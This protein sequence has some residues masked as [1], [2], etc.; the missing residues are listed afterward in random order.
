MSHSKQTNH[1]LSVSPC[2]L[3]RTSSQTCARGNLQTGTRMPPARRRC[4]Q[5]FGLWTSCYKGMCVPWDTGRRDGTCFSLPCIHS[6]RAIGGP[7]PRSFGGRYIN[8]GRGCATKLLSPPEPGDYH[9]H[10]SSL[11]Y[12]ERRA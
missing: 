11:I 6:T 2:S 3:Q 8:S 1:G 4:L 12:S 5:S 10:F 7:F 9:S